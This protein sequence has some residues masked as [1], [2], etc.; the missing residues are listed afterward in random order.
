MTTIHQQRIEW[1]GGT[2]QQMLIGDWWPP[3]TNKEWTGSTGP[4]HQRVPSKRF[5]H[6]KKPTQISN[7][8]TGAEVD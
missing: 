8:V 7:W 5:A 6:P 1:F 2:R 3:C 4:D